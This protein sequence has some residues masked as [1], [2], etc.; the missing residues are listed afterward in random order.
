MTS[1]EHRN[2]ARMVELTTDIQNKLDELAKLVSDSAFDLDY[3]L[4]DYLIEEHDV[5][6]SDL[7]QRLRIRATSVANMIEVLRHVMYIKETGSISVLGDWIGDIQNGKVDEVGARLSEKTRLSR[8][9]IAAVVGFFL[10][11]RR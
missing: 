11:P 6:M 1:K 8:H 10:I 7:S 4:N 2:A 5:K 9:D 3:K